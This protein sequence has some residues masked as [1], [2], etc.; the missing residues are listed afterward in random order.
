M[1]SGRGFAPNTAHAQPHDWLCV[2]GGSIG[3]GPPVATGA[4]I[5]APGRK[6][7]NLEGDG[8]AMYTLQALWTQA[9]ERLDVTTIVLANRSYNI[10]HGEFAAVGAG[11]PGRR[12][13][14]M[15]TLDRPYLDW[16]SLARGH[17]VEAGQATT[18]DGLV[19][20]LRRGLAAPGPY[21]IELVF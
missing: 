3:F 7:I 8:S 9:R 2:T 16:Q 13:S 10:L 21:L 19:V 20:Q 14:D 17:G 12:A 5:G 15:L 11:A 18:L 6:V 1:S 4:A